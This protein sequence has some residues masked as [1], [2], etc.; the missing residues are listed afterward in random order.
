MSRRLSVIVCGAGPAS[1]VDRLI[2]KAQSDG[3]D[4]QLIATPSGLPFLDIEALETLTGKPV[5]TDY[6]KPGEQRSQASDAVIIAPATYNTINKLAA[7]VS[8]TYALGIAAEAIGLGLRVV[9]LPFVN[10]ALA[11][12]EPFKR[13]ID[14]LRSEGVEVVLGPGQWEP[15]EPHTGGDYFDRFPWERAVNHVG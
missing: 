7:G 4:V 12:R 14:A 5:R 15:H 3:W 9:I 2:R 10:S 1:D 13:S 8:D 6:R 11:N